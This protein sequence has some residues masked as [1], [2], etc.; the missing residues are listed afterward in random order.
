MQCIWG[1]TGA[2]AGTGR[3]PTLSTVERNLQRRSRAARAGVA[4]WEHRE[5]IWADRFRVHCPNP[6]NVAGQRRHRRRSTVQFV[7][8][9]PLYFVIA[10]RPHADHMPIIHADRTPIRVAHGLRTVCAQFAHG[11][12]TVCGR[13]AHGLRTV[14]A[15]SFPCTGC[16][17]ALKKL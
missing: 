6:Q 12:P 7:V 3:P 14:C 8:T 11:L 5:A 17:K 13:L 15:R 2:C 4:P 1:A 16:L 10:C 9:P